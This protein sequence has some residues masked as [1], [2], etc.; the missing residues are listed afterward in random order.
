MWFLL[1]CIINLVGGGLLYCIVNL[2]G[3]VCRESTGLDCPIVPLISGSWWFIG[4]SW[5]SARGSRT[6]GTESRHTPPYRTWVLWMK[7]VQN[8]G[9]SRFSKLGKL[10]QNCMPNWDWTQGLMGKGQTTNY[11]LQPKNLSKTLPKYTL[12]RERVPYSKVLYHHTLFSKI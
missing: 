3:G 2:V 11:K 6:S 7:C 1:F 9:M 8:K 5:Y 4:I 12:P 10:K